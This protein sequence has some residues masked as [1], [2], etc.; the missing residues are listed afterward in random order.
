M[1]VQLKR[2]KNKLGSHNH[3]SHHHSEAFLLL[4][5]PHRRAAVVVLLVGGERVQRLALGDGLLNGL[6]QHHVSLRH[7]RRHQACIAD[8][9]TYGEYVVIDV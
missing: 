6:R 1:T 3:H 4:S 9:E 2:A 5:L 7:Q 8:G